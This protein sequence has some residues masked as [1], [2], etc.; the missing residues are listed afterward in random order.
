[1]DY[2]VVKIEDINRILGFDI[3]KRSR[4]KSIVLGRQGAWFCFNLNGYS[5]SEIGR[6]FNITPTSVIEGINRFEDR[7]KEKD[8]LTLEIWDKL[9]VYDF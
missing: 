7:L 9:K 3:S 8:S 2:K 6:I 5:Y 1:M 4:D